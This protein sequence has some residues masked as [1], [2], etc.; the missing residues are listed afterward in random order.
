MDKIRIEI[1]EFVLALQEHG[2]YVQWFL[3]KQ[4]GELLPVF[5][6]SCGVE[7]NEEIEERIKKDPL[8]YLGIDPVSSHQSFQIMEDFIETLANQKAQMD[9]SRAISM[10]RPFAN[11]KTTLCRFP[12]IGEKWFL[13][14]EQ[15]ILE[16][17]KEWLASEHIEAKFF[18][19]RKGQTRSR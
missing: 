17:G 19:I 6:D 9:L 12:E 7:E 11:F 13:Y 5:E 4:S 16:I 10:K 3:D 8:R 2:P 18:D 15:A 1:D 14:N